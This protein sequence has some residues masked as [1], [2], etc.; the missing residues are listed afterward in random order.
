MVNNNIDHEEI[1][2]NLDQC[3]EYEGEVSI[4][5]NGLVSIEGDV[6]LVRVDKMPIKQ[7]PVM[8]KQVTGALMLEDNLLETLEGCPPHVGGHFSCRDNQLLKLDHGPSTVDGRYNCSENRLTNLLGAPKNVPGGFNCTYNPLE[9]LDGF[10]EYIGDTLYISWNKH[11]PM[12]RTLAARKI[13]FYAMPVAR[14]PAEQVLEIL[15]RY[16][17]KGEAGAFECGAELA[18]AGFKENARW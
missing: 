9:T 2:E 4:D 7:L 5:S 12:L 3:F 17:G 8:F 18:T 1:M 10:P 16:A 15:N 6:F 14:G 11:L 13:V